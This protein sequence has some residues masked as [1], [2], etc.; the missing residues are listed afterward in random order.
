MR[1]VADENIPYLEACFGQSA[2]VVALNGRTLTQSDVR[3]ADALIVRSVTPVTR[4]LL[5]GSAVRFV[6]SCT[7]GI[8]HVDTDYLDERGISF[9]SAPGSNADSAAQYTLAALLAMAQ[10]KGADLRQQTIGIVGFGN[11]GS[12]LKT[13]LDALGVRTLINDPFLADRGK[14][15][16]LPLNEVLQADVVSFHVPLTRGGKYP[17]YRMINADR[18]AAMNPE[19]VLINCARGDIVDAQALQQDIQQ[20]G[21]KVVLDVW[22][23]EPRIDELLLSSVQIGTPHIAGYSF[24][25]KL[26]GTQ[27]VYQALCEA[28]NIP[29]QTP[30]LSLDNPEP[31]HIPHDATLDEAVAMAVTHSYQI[32]ADDTALRE[33]LNEDRH[34]QGA[35]FDRLRKH[36]SV[37]REFNAYT[38]HV[39]QAEIADVLQALGFQVVRESFME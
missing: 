30:Q 26:R 22:P 7:I 35:Y 24:D 1:V 21:R 5:E 28:S 18:L 31:I 10:R 12:R 14:P 3:D 37:R 13:L 16:L 23:H 36:Y 2:E 8:D 17:T 39:A 11:V 27:M 15:G 32:L 6:G 25:G 33:L 4:E 9:A 20:H 29:Y 19:T 38:C 34:E